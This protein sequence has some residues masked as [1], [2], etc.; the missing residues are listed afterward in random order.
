[1]GFQDIVSSPSPNGYTLLYQSSR[2]ELETGH[3]PFLSAPDELAA[4]LL[5]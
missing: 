3:L 1:L 5:E 4:M 2:R